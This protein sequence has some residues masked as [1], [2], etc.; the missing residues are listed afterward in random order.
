[1]FIK[2]VG[3]FLIL[4]SGSS[5]GWII[6]SQYLYRVKILRELQLAISI[7]DNEVSYGQTLLADAFQVI[8]KGVDYPIS[9]LFK[10]AGQKLD[11]LEGRSFPEIWNYL[12]K[13]NIYT[14]SLVNE[15]LKILK[16]WGQQIG[17]SSLEN[18]NKINELTIKRLEQAEKK[19]QKVAE[20]RV[21]IT[22][23]SGVLISLLVIIIFY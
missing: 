11:Q 12:L 17:S 6:S 5:I 2:L 15:D 7:F 22:R 21:K 4:I 18:Q 3:A 9:E 16:D 10:V 23:Y 8:S 1:M 20:K 19:A 13:N 14:G